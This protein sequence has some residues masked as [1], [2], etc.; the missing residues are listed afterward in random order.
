MTIPELAEELNRQSVDFK[1]GNL[2]EMRGS[3]CTD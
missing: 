3:I 1:I 2:Q